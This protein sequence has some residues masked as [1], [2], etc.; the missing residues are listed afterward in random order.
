LLS[1]IVHIVHF[2]DCCGEE[3]KKNIA[4]KL[5]AGRFRTLQHLKKTLQKKHTHELMVRWMLLVIHSI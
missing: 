5:E 1:F 2:A 4:N 3:G